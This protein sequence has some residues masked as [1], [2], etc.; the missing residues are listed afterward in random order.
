MTIAE[1]DDWRHGILHYLAEKG[2]LEPGV[3]EVTMARR[4]QEGI[5]CAVRELDAGSIVSTAA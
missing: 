4:L 5:E 3:S 2:E 1:L